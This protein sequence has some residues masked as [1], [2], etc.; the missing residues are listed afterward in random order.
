M[1]LASVPARFVLLNALPARLDAWLN[2]SQREN[3]SVF[4]TVSTSAMTIIIC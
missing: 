1:L 4:M 3:A 2:L